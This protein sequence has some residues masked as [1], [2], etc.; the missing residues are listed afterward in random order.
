MINLDHRSKAIIEAVLAPYIA[1]GTLWVFGSRTGE[2]CD[3]CSDLDLLIK[4][5][6]AIALDD[7]LALKDALE[8]SALPMRVDLLD[9]HRMSAEFRQNI[10]PQCEPWR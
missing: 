3:R 6:E 5:D 9:W 8:F 1:A 7:Y 2:H 10:E 4:A